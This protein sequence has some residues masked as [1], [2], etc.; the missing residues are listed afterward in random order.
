MPSGVTI[1]TVPY[2][3]VYYLA[4]QF[5]LWFVH[6]IVVILLVEKMSLFS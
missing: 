6:P 5:E 4:A 1:A 2:T 3:D